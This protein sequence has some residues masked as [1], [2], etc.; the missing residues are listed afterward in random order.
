M[1]SII[2]KETGTADER[3]QVAGVFV[4]RLNTRCGCKPTRR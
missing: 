2:E 3:P 4:N 1:A